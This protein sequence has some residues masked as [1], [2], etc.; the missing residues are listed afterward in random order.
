MIRTIENM[1]GRE[2]L[3]DLYDYWRHEIF[4]K[5]DSVFTE[6]L[7][8]IEVRLQADGQWPPADIPA[9]PIV[10]VANHP[11]GIGDGIAFLSL[12]EQLGRPFRVIINNDLMKVPEIRPYS[13]PISFEETKEAVAL[14]LATR[15]EA[16]RLLKEGVTIVIF[17]AGGVATARKGLGRAEDLPWK[18]FT[19]R[20]IQA[21]NASV[22]PVYF[23]GQN[24][25]LFH[26]VSQFSL[27]LRT[28]LLIREFQRLYGRQIRAWVGR[29]MPWDDLSKIADRK[30]LLETVQTAV[31]SLDPSQRPRRP[32]RAT[33]SE[34][35]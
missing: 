15:K 4:G 19:A 10:M 22:I 2:R 11:Y 14:N 16:V 20:L 33:I 34:R 1:S 35:Y 6:M 7:N 31:F 23:D 21:A 17:P 27:T 25:R 12:A 26:L 30:V 24:G 3:A 28:S 8:L 18:M 29:T 32:A 13:L 9:T 5:S